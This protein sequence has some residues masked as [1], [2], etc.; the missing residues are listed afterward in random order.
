MISPV[1]KKDALKELID[2]FYKAAGES[3]WDGP[4]NESVARV[5]TDM[6]FEAKRCLNDESWALRPPDD[7]P[8]TIDW[9]I[10]QLDPYIIFRMEVLNENSTCLEFV[11]EKWDPKL[12]V[13]S[14][15]D[16]TLSDLDFDDLDF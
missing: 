1:E 3:G 13:A 8:V 12:R 4:V 16:K 10:Y 15:H 7:G 2:T 14:K 6:L 11:V 5:F 9:L